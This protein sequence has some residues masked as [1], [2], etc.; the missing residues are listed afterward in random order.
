MTTAI[1]YRDNKIISRFLENGLYGITGNEKVGKT[2]FQITLRLA[3]QQRQNHGVV[4]TSSAGIPKNNPYLRQQFSGFTNNAFPLFVPDSFFSQTDYTEILYSWIAENR[5]RVLFID[6]VSTSADL[7]LQQSGKTLKA[8]ASHF[9]IPIFISIQKS[10]NDATTIPQPF[11][12]MVEITKMEFFEKVFGETTVA[13]RSR[14]QSAARRLLLRSNF[15][16]FKF[17]L[18]NDQEDDATDQKL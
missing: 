1:A 16:E 4:T 17:E 2:S 9:A 5:I 10:A 18:L 3:L 12:K 11:D 8:M 7:S 15:E 13:V 6:N 14:E